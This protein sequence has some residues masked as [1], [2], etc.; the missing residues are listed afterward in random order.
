MK[1]LNFSNKGDLMKRGALFYIFINFSNVLLRRKQL[2]SHIYF[3][4]QTAVL[5][6]EEMQP[7][8]HLFEKVGTFWSW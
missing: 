8:K 6:Y 5:V 7:H 2:A 4:T 1:H 3:C